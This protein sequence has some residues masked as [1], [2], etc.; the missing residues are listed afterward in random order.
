[1]HQGKRLGNRWMPRAC[2]IVCPWYWNM[3]FALMAAGVL[4]VSYDYMFSG[5][6]VLVLTEWHEN[7]Q[8]AIERHHVHGE[9]EGKSVGYYPSGQIAMLS[10]F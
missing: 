5:G 7:G 3:L 9:R 8:L 2:W 4:W 6:Q 10:Q 1:M